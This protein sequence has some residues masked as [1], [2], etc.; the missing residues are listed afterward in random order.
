MAFLPLQEGDGYPDRPD[1]N[2]DVRLLQDMLNRA[3][4]TKLVVD[5]KYG[6]STVAAFAEHIGGD[7][8]NVRGRGFENLLWAYTRKAAGGDHSH[9]ATVE[10]S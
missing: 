10:L 6:P 9:S 2:Q 1:H 5:G 3:Y 7:G 8:K 4:N